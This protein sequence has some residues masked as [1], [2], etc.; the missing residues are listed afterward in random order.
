MTNKDPKSVLLLG[1]INVDMYFPVDRYPEPGQ[2]GFAEEISAHLG[3]SVVNTAVVLQKMGAQTNMIGCLGDDS[4]GNQAQDW[5]REIGI[6]LNGVQH[7]SEKQSGLS[8]LVVTPDNERTMFTHRGANACL[9]AEGI[10]PLLFESADIIHLSGYAFM[11]GAQRE[12][13]W[14]AVALAKSAGIKISVDTGLDAVLKVPNEFRR[15]IPQVDLVITGM[16]EMS[17]LYGVDT[18][19]QA[20][21]VLMENGVSLTG[22]KLGA[23]GSYVGN[24]QQNYYQKAFPVESVDTTGAG[25]TYSAGMI[26]GLLH[27]LS[28]EETGQLA[29]GLGALATMVPGAGSGLPGND[30]LRHFYLDQGVVFDFHKI[31]F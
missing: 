31:G 9:R 17:E 3:G 4:W 26:L 1:D 2:E 23:D 24:Q 11:V 12:A 20:Y 21:Q 7:A 5:L 6:G 28:V 8:M 15:L 27:H 22:I 13:A 10:S 30:T 25:D 29:S 14:Q 18:I 16:K 19:E